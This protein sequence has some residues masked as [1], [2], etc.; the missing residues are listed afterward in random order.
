MKNIETAFNTIASKIDAYKEKNQKLFLE[1]YTNV[2]WEIIE[3]KDAI[4]EIE[5]MNHT[6]QEWRNIL[7]LVLLKGLREEGVQQNHQLTPDGIGFLFAFILE[8]LHPS[9]QNLKLFD[10]AVGMGNLLFTVQQSLSLNRENIS[11]LGIDVDESLIEVAE[12]TAQFLNLPSETYVLDG[13]SP[14]ENFEAD[15]ALSEPAV[16]FYPDDT[17]AA[18][19]SSHDK[20]EHTYAHHLLIEAAMKQVKRNSFGLFLLP[21]NFLSSPQSG[22][23]KTFLSREVYLQGVFQLPTSLF[24]DKA[25]EKSLFLLQKH[26][27]NAQQQQVLAYPIKSL[28][29]INELEKFTKI[30]KEWAQSFAQ[31]GE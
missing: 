5:N 17:R 4:Q 19:F 6:P 23:M 22:N 24:K 20:D 1:S 18:L 12:A 26:G 7:Q 9:Y 11:S 25:S 27:E 3:E 29:D 2:L 8:T 15:I 30:F 13:L 10:N 31:K 21:S 16:G 28:K 14:I